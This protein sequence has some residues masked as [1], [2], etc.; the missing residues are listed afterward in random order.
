MC[1]FH[2][3]PL[4]SVGTMM[5]NPLI[6]EIVRFCTLIMCSVSV[7]VSGL[8][9]SIC[10]WIGSGL[11][12]EWKDAIDVGNIISLII[13][14][15][16]RSECSCKLRRRFRKDLYRLFFYSNENDIHSHNKTLCTRKMLLYSFQ[17][18]LNCSPT[19]PYSM[20]VNIGILAI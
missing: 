20:T 14:C 15:G 7:N 2:R 11:L 18:L 8:L 19:R 4:V 3:R 10:D 5:K 6:S 17:F 13:G 1:P 9:G 12:T 16:N